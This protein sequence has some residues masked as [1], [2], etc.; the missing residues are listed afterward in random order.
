MLHG[1]NGTRSWYKLGPNERQACAITITTSREHDS[2]FIKHQVMDE[3]HP[4]N[5]HN[6][7]WALLST[8]AHN[9]LYI[10]HWHFDTC[11][12]PWTWSTAYFPQQPPVSNPEP[13]PHHPPP[14]HLLSRPIF[15]HGRHS[16]RNQQC[17]SLRSQSRR[18][19]GTEWSVQPA[20]P[21]VVVKAGGA[22]STR[23]PARTSCLH[24]RPPRSAGA[25]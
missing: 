20:T 14:S 24:L 15:H 21:V 2:E 13:S 6:G 18:S 5:A 17:L 9:L 7:Q 16:R 23:I 4:I 8:N 3:K 22:P 19:E 1:A 12:H 11:F 10:M 25:L